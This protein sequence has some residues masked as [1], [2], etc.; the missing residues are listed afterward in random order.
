MELCFLLFTGGYHGAGPQIPVAQTL[1]LKVSDMEGGE[2][3][4]ST[5]GSS[6][7]TEKTHRSVRGVCPDFSLPQQTPKYH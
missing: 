5:G 6:C 1:S 2:S 3:S 7:N 4:K